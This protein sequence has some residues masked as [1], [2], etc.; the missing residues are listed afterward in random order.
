MMQS[1]INQILAYVPK[2]QVALMARETG[3]PDCRGKPY[4]GSK[5][6]RD[7]IEMVAKWC[8]N[9]YA[10]DL[11]E[12]GV[13]AGGTT[14]RLAKLAH[15]YNRRVV[16]VDPWIPSTTG[17]KAHG[18]CTSSTML[19][20]FANTK[21]YRHLIDVI[22]AYS[23]A[24]AVVRSIKKRALCF[25]YIDGAHFYE[26]CSTDIETVSH[27]AGIIMLDDLWMA[28]VL[29]AFEEAGQKPDREAFSHRVLAEGY[30][31]PVLHVEDQC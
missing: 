14:V 23:Q 22:H 8:L 31:L 9:R 29:Q 7:R 21:K 18:G 11:I 4:M 28:G 6:K 13:L 1:L 10:G 2:E 3:R 20:F 25:A 24:E 15:Q 26:E 12:I 27:C 30:L 17:Y 19:E 16:A 5:Y